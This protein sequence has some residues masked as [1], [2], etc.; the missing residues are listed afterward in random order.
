MTGDVVTEPFHQRA[1]ATRWTTSPRRNAAGS[2]NAR[3]GGESSAARRRQREARGRRTAKVTDSGCRAADAV[4]LHSSEISSELTRSV[5]GA[6]APAG[7]VTSA[8]K[9]RAVSGGTW[10]VS[11]PSP[12]LATE[13]PPSSAVHDEE[14]V[15]VVSRL[16]AAAKREYV[17]AFNSGETPLRLTVT[18]STGSSS[19]TALLGGSSVASSGDGR[20]TLQVPPL[21]ARLFRADAT[22]PAGA[23]APVTLRVSS[24]EISEL[25]S[26][27]ASA[28]RQPESVTFAV[29]RPGG[30]RWRRLAADDS[31][32]LR[33]FLDPAAF[34]RGEVVHLVAVARWRN[35]SVTTSPVM[36]FTMRRA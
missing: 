21:T 18:T 15:D 3:S 1:T 20:L 22:L 19:W 34:R 29:R 7:R 12:A 4:T 32:P 36:P 31:P 10:S 17:A 2:R 33:A 25:W 8:R 30:S 28:A 14:P 16:D 26:V 11:R 5:T 13:D 27:T 24:D 23:A 6:A 9:S 35:G